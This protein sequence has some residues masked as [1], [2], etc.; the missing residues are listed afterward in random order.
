MVSQ[1]LLMQL[2]SD[3]QKI[4]LHNSPDFP[5]SAYYT[6]WQIQKIR[7]VPWHWHREL[8]FM[9]VVEGNVHVWFDNQDFILQEG[10]GVFCNSRCLH[11]FQMTRCDRCR[12]HSLVFDHQLICGGPGTIFDQKYIYPLISARSVPGSILLGTDSGHR[13]ILDHIKTAHQFCQE[14]PPGYEYDVR[15]HLSKALLLILEENRALLQASPSGALQVGRVRNMLDYIHQNYASPITLSSL[16]ASANIC[17]R[18]CQRCFQKVLHQSPMDYL[19]QY[20]MQM[21]GKLLLETN[22][23][24]LNIGLA[25]G[26]SNPS[27]F[28]KIFRKHMSCSPAKFRSRNT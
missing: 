6:D 3:Q 15:Y 21:A 27:H 11:Q 13:Q 17:E 5:C 28:C 10:D 2:A 7:G 25:V 18:E 20:R 9:F 16:A 24:I 1:L 26:L 23:S 4:Q 12:V 8:E 14:E 22:D 19:Q